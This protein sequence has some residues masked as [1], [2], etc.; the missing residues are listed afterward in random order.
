[1]HMSGTMKKNFLTVLLCLI[2][3][4]AYGQEKTYR[5]PGANRISKT[6][7]NYWTFNYFPGEEAENGGYQ[8]PDYNDATWSSVSVPHTWQ[9][10]ET[11]QELHPYIRNASAKDDPY[12]WNGWGW[13]R[14]HILIDSKFEGKNICLE[15]DGV[16]KYSKIYVNGKYIGD[17]KGGFTSFYMD[18]TSA[19]KFGSD[20][21]IVVAVNNSLND[22]FNIS[23]MNAGNWVVY[24]GIVRDVRL[25]ITDKLKVPYQGSYKHEGGTF[26]TTPR[27]TDKSADI[28]VKTYVQNNYEQPKEVKLVTCLTDADNRVIARMESSR[29]IT[30]GEIA[31]FIQRAQAPDPN[32]WSPETPYIYNAYTEV[33]DGTRLVDTYR[34][35]FGIR[36]VEWD[37][38][39]HRLVLNGKLT[40]LHG[41]NRHEEYVWLGGAFPKWIAD[42]DMKDIA[43]G[44]E[45]NYMRTAHYPNAP[46]VYSF[47][48]RRGICINEELPN[49]KNQEFDPK[50]QEQN[51]REMIR[52]DRNHPS[53]IAWS[54]GNETDHACDS[55]YAWEEDTTR[56]I[57]VR[58]PYNEA[59]NPEF[60]KHTDAEMPLESY[61]RCTIRGWY[62][63]DDR[64]MEPDD[65]QWAGTD[66]W[67]HVKSAEE[68]VISEHNGTVW[69]YADHGADREYVGAPLKHVNPKGWVDSW[70]TPKYVYYLWQANF[71]KRPMVFV[72]PHFWRNQYIGQKKDF[73]V[74]SNCPE[75]ELFVNGKSY[76]VRN[77]GKSNNF[78][79]TFKDIPVQTGTI[80]VVATAVDGSKVSD[81]VVMAGEPAFLTIEPTAYRMMSTPDHIIEFKVD[82][83][84]K[85]GVHVYGAANMLKFTIEG[86]ARLVGPD[87]Y[88][89][90][91]DKKEEYE[92]TMYIDTPVTN[93]I[94]AVGKTGRVKVTVSSPGLRPASVEVDVVPYV[95]PY[96]VEGIVEPVVDFS[97][98]RSVAVNTVQANFVKAPQEMKSFTDE[99]RF[100]IAQQAEYKRLVKEYI[101][102]RNPGIGTQSVDFEYAL[103]AL[104]AILNSTAKYTHEYGYIVAD[105]SNFIAEQYNTSRAI[106]RNIRSKNLPEAYRN[107]LCG[108]YASQ[109]ILKGRD[110]N[111]IA[112]NA[113]IDSIPE[114]GTAV[115]IAEAG[116]VKGV[117]CIPQTD[118][119]K[120]LSIVR[121]ASV[122]WSADERKKAMMMIVHINPSADYKSIRNMKTKERVDSFI[123]E[124]GHVILIP[125]M[126]VLKESSFPDKKL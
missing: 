78:S 56:I 32:L 41:I 55:R 107:E 60:C 16:Q 45:V 67:Q 101:M 53:I 110:K 52:R 100:P 59:Y 58:Q 62:D 87:I 50:V 104:V 66:Y 63:K 27:V 14:K 85:D 98:A 48:D 70:R 64:N 57:T 113:L 86:P 40:H 102:E 76:G 8:E 123:L 19:V 29:K 116:R 96:P 90:D 89:S 126:Q 25:V 105:D 5:M 13:Y 20:N 61:L 31:E 109:I 68:G 97:R 21:V 49:I 93:L 108:Y 124:K 51:C 28:Q 65:N 120:L 125:D 77:P 83:V 81:K 69:L 115:M 4:G 92:G 37:Y 80:E 22:R 71:A 34:T 26:I 121:P 103:E 82:I 10:Y 91:R 112:E 111:F 54:M 33:Y 15:F 73:V 39:A 9:T 119:S 17:H 2:M 12:W 84:D 7:N 118:L 18:I 114:G 117:E 88:I 94:R 11:T 35:E 3:W 79:V 122:E 72:M 30:P 74:D 42:R 38:D 99:I 46:Y 44:L 1:M 36:T 24:G 23:P 47:M 95:D 6:V 43:D 106:T 75:V